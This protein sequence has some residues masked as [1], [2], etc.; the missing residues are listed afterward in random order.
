MPPEVMLL[1]IGSSCR[2]TCTC[3][4]WGSTSYAKPGRL[5]TARLAHGGLFDS[6]EQIAEGVMVEEV[7]SVEM[8][9]L[10]TSDR[11]FL[12]SY[13]RETDEAGID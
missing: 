10:R 6:S 12:N 11:L 8:T 9:K 5:E 1:L 7:K 4:G 2:T 3:L 13:Y